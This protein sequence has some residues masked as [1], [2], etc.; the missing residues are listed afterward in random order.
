MDPRRGDA[1]T[2]TTRAAPVCDPCERTGSEPSIAEISNPS[3]DER[4]ITILASEP[5]R[6]LASPEAAS[7]ARFA[8]VPAGLLSGA[9]PRN[10]ITSNSVAPASARRLAPAFLSPAERASPASVH[11]SR[12]VAEARVSPGSVVPREQHRLINSTCKLGERH[13][14]WF[15]P[16]LRMNAPRTLR[17]RAASWRAAPVPRRYA[18][19]GFDHDRCA[20]R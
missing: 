6:N 15:C 8:C 20:L 1:M 13:G 7:F 18:R 14:V 9:C 17:R 19:R 3:P 10:D 4:W 12:H 16:G 11:Q 2:R 5:V